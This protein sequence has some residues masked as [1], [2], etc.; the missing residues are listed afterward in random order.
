MPPATQPAPRSSPVRP[1]TPRRAGVRARHS[2]VA[3]ASGGCVHPHVERRRAMIGASPPPVTHASLACEQRR[4]GPTYAAECYLA[5]SGSSGDPAACS[6][7]MPGRDAPADDATGAYPAGGGP[8]PGKRR[9]LR[10]APGP[11]PARPR[12]RTRGDR[13]RR[14]RGPGSRARLHLLEARTLAA[15][16]RQPADVLERALHGAGHAVE[17]VRGARARS[18]SPSQR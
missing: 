2:P 6:P 1:S 15:L 18:P 4:N 10:G 7:G 9:A 16:G 13:T 11:A 12:H 17:A 8:E 5:G 3:C 14:D